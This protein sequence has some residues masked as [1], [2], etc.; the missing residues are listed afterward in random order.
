MCKILYVMILA[1]CIGSLNAANNLLRNGGFENGSLNYWESKQQAGNKKK[2]FTLTLSA[3]SGRFAICASGNKQNKYNGFTTLVQNIEARV[4][5]G[6]QY[7]LQ[8]F[9]KA[10]V[11]NTNGK[12]F[13]IAIRQVNAKGGSVVYTKIPIVLKKDSWEYYVKQFTPHKDT[14]KFQAYLIASNLSSEDKVYID[15]ICF[16]LV[17]SAGKRFDSAK[18]IQPNKVINLKDSNLNLKINSTTG[19]LQ[20]L[21][22]QKQVIHPQASDVSCVYVEKNGKETL[23]LR[24][25]KTSYLNT[26]NN[27]RAQLTTADAKVPFVADIEYSIKDGAL[28]EK[29]TFTATS[30]IN[31]PIKLGVRHGFNSRKWKIYSVPSVLY[32]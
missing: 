11:K 24:N 10:N 7:Q 19:L 6:K 18:K 20:E 15:D 32:A 27:Y 17:Q 8:C 14:V 30:D 9:A 21:I 25:P 16:S 13:S 1:T 28:S 2:L 5:K 26:K 4:I 3:K 23:F 12:N 29:V 22:L 31:Y